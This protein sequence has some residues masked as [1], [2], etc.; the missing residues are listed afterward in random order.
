[1]FLNQGQQRKATLHVTCQYHLK[2]GLAMLLQI[3]WAKTNIL[4]RPSLISCSFSTAVLT[5]VQSLQ[6][7]AIFELQITVCRTRNRWYFSI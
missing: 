7:R 6:R 3:I 2:L 4:F 1:M 5:T